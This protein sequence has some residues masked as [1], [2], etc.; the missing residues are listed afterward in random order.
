MTSSKRE[1]VVYLD[2]FLFDLSKMRWLLIAFANC[3]LYLKIIS[4]FQNDALFADFRPSIGDSRCRSWGI[5]I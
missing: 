3:S 4:S 2:G 5:C 1:I